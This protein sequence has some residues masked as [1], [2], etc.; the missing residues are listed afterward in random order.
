VNTDEKIIEIKKLLDAQYYDICGAA[1]IAEKMCN[2]HSCFS[3]DWE[4]KIEDYRIKK[5]KEIIEAV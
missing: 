2:C 3:C 4:K 1:G 5:L